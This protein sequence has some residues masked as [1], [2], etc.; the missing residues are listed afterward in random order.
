MSTSLPAIRAFLAGRA[1]FRMGDLARPFASFATRRCWTRPSR[2]PR[3]SWCTSR[4]GSIGRTTPAAGSGWRE[5]GRSRLSRD[6]PALLD[7]WPLITRFPTAPELLGRWRAAAEAFP[8]R[9]EIWYWFGDAYY[10]AGRSRV[11]TIGWT[12]RSRLSAGAG[13]WTRPRHALAWR[14]ALAPFCGAADAHGRD[15]PDEGR[16]GLGA[17][18]QPARAVRRL[19]RRVGLVP[20]LAPG[21]RVSATRPDAPSGPTP[22]GSTREPSERSAGS[23]RPTA[24]ARRIGSGRSGSTSETRRAAG[25]R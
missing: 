9:A 6:D 24:S 15:R 19:D 18:T 11:W 16:H 23:S 4:S 1:A 17:P 8:D 10:H 25:P 2:W 21:G 12:W 3:S 20:P 5:A 14:A 13:R 22:S 7:A